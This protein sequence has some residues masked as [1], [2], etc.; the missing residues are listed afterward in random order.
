[1]LLGSCLLLIGLGVGYAAWSF[2]NGLR[3]GTALL[4]RLG[5]CETVRPEAHHGSR[6]L[7]VRGTVGGE[8]LVLDPFDGTPCA[9]WRITVEA[10]PRTQRSARWSTV[11][12][13][14]TAAPFVLHETGGCVVTVSAVGDR[15][16]SPERRV[17]SGLADALPQ[18]V[19]R[20]LATRDIAQTGLF[21]TR[22]LRVE[23]SRLPAGIACTVVG[24]PQR[25]EGSQGFRDLSAARLHFAT[26][27]AVTPL[28]L[29]ALR[30]RLAADHRVLGT[31]RTVL[32][33]VSTGLLTGA[34]GVLGSAL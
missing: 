16:D 9:W 3:V 22:R 7:A 20:Y 24:V 25:V 8:H 2:H 26:P 32:A 11:D 34:L 19:Q 5:P 30:E 28:T 4:R 10:R 1:M 27:E 33:V 29:P 21:L 15:V 31:V 14:R 23:A 18:E 12:D 13:H 17:W 6:L